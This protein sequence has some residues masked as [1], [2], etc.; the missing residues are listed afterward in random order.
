MNA[1]VLQL[2]EV[3][4]YKAQNFLP[5]LNHQFLLGAVMGW[6]LFTFF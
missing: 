4:D 2:K 6:F 5:P 1:N 3:G